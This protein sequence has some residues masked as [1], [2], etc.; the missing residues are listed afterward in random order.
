MSRYKYDRAPQRF[1]RPTWWVLIAVVLVT[2][3]LAGLAGAAV[4]RATINP[5]S[6]RS[7]STSQGDTTIWGSLDVQGET[8]LHGPMRGNFEDYIWMRDSLV[9]EG[10]GTQPQLLVRGQP[11]QVEPLFMIQEISGD[12]TTIL[13][14]Q[15]NLTVT[16]N[17]ELA[18]GL[19]AL[20]TPNYDVKIIGSMTGTYTVT[21]LYVL[22]NF[23]GLDESV[24]AG[25][26]SGSCTLAE[27][28]TADAASCAITGHLWPED[29][30]QAS[31]FQIRIRVYKADNTL[32]TVP[33]AAHWYALVRP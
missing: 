7:G 33:A 3:V 2:L 6:M 26:Y 16:G 23:G 5:V 13:D 28:P 12:P 15:G 30:G 19:F 27:P 8:T 14:Y 11:N 21:G 25:F 10:D 29:Q 9:I 24:F 22:Q 4:G 20:G 32:A 31:G 17:I 1:R 18:N